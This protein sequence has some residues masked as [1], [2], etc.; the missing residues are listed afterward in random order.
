MAI[1][2]VIYNILSNY[3]PLVT[4]VSNKIFP[5]RILHGTSFPAITYHQVSVTPSNTKDQISTL[6]FIRVQ[7]SIFATDVN[8]VSGF[9]KANSVAELVRYAMEGKAVTL[10]TEIDGYKVNQ[11]FYDGE[12]Q[13][14]D[15]EAGIEGV[16]Q[17]AQDYIIGYNRVI[18][19][20]SI[21]YL[22]TESGDFLL[23]ENG[24]KIIL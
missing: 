4:E 23:L 19:P 16:Y 17:I 7:V 8:G 18:T 10:P 13:M 15:D 11:I 20:P 6:D 3:S 5:L 12:V 24:G 9:E 21:N 2:N 1:T 14:S 22:L